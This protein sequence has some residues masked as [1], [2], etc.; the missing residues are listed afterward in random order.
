MGGNFVFDPSSAVGRSIRIRCARNGVTDCIHGYCNLH[1]SS[2]RLSPDKLRF[3]MC[4][5]SLESDP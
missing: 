2:V 4:S 3:V 5:L 1:G